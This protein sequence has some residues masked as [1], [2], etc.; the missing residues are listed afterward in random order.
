MA[1]FTRLCFA[2]SPG[3]PRD[4]MPCGNR[5]DRVLVPRPEQDTPLRDMIGGA[6]FVCWRCLNLMAKGKRAR[7]EAFG[8]DPDGRVYERG[9]ANAHA[10]LGYLEDA[11]A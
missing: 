11:T 8:L 5:A 2:P 6:V 3:H 1:P 7:Y 9:D 4:G 10:T